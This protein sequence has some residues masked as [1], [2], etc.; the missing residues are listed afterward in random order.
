MLNLGNF[1]DTP[2]YLFVQDLV[3]NSRIE[4]RNHPKP[5]RV[6]NEGVE[7]SETEQVLRK[8]STNFQCDL[9]PGASCPYVCT[10][11]YTQ[12]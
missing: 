5:K 8:T 4:E 10:N 9:R 1:R 11:A 6:I 7:K 3:D 2:D 12:V